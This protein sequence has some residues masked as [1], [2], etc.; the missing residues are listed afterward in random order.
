MN[1]DVV[2]SLWSFKGSWSGVDA[3][4]PPLAGADL[5]PSGKGFAADAENRFSVVG[6]STHNMHDPKGVLLEAD[7][8]EGALG[9]YLL[10]NGDGHERHEDSVHIL[11]IARVSPPASGDDDEG[12]FNVVATGSNDFGAF[13]ALGFATRVTCARDRSIRRFR[14]LE[15]DSCATIH[16]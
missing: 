1:V 6:S 8:G 11:R 10:D 12:T 2:P 15:F 4:K 13:L 5:C 14:F 7:S 9:W 16:W 3:P